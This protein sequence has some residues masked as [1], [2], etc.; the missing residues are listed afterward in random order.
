MTRS[1]V[2][3]CFA[4]AVA[5][6]AEPPRTYGALPLSFAANRGQAPREIRFVAQGP[7]YRVL[8]SANSAEI[9][10][11]GKAIR[12]T[13]VGAASSPRI[14]G[15]QPLWPVHYLIGRD[16]SHWRTNVQTYGRVLYHSVYPGIDLVYYGNDRRLEY[17]FTVAP[18]ADPRAIRLKIGGSENMA[19][20]GNGDLILGP[21]RL[22]KPLAYQT[23][24]GAR[25]E[26][27][28]AYQV[29]GR[30]VGFRTGSYDRTRPLVIDPV[31]VYSTY[32]GGSGWDEAWS[33]AVDR[34]GNAYVAGMT[35]SPD[36]PVTPGVAQPGL[37]SAFIAKLNPAGT[38]LVYATYFGGT[39]GDDPERI[40]VDEQ[41]NV[42]V[43][44]QTASPDF[45]IVNPL[46]QPPAQPIGTWQY[47]LAK[48][49]PDGSRLL[50]STLMPD[51]HGWVSGL[52]LD[53]DGNVWLTGAATAN[54][55]WV[56]ALQEYARL[57]S[58][59]RS[60]D[61]GVT[62]QSAGA[63][64]G[65]WGNIV[66][67]AVDPKSP[68]NLYAVTSDWDRYKLTGSTPCSTGALTAA[69]RGPRRRPLCP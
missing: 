31:F 39:L 27:S 12:M 22:G 42:Y 25:R 61:R 51:A 54:W 19:V 8:L 34:D 47:F 50:Y 66:A 40:A 11:G 62:W 35:V 5:A 57:A 52:A 7:G 59:Y 60:A 45:P 1:I 68:L 13:L 14:E 41:H 6:D 65:L 15:A 44:G 32:L 26:V 69:G 67:V 33:I 56:N 30:R 4:I 29:H 36:F 55:P 21:L 49:S 58:I 23:L 48:L 16:P 63:R 43:L 9:G 18:G 37:A 20:S 28:C 3:A 53:P 38:A 46:F 24:D 17:D 2:L 10:A 64:P